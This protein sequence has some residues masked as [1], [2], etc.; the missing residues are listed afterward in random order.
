MKSSSVTSLFLV[1]SCSLLLTTEASKVRGAR[2][3]KNRALKSSK[4][5][6][7][8]MAYT[9]SFHVVM[10]PE[11]AV[12]PWVGPVGELG[13]ATITFPREAGKS[14][15]ACIVASSTFAPELSHI[16]VVG[17]TTNPLGSNGPAM[18]SFTDLID[19]TDVSGCVDIE[20]DLYE[21]IL[22]EP[23]SA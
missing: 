6:S 7:G 10:T 16:H 5:A 13:M 11:N 18:I 20:V 17:D 1:F 8:K 23:V 12:A 22:T 2:T 9:P 4:K 15:Q 19:G 14:P 21:A 3:N